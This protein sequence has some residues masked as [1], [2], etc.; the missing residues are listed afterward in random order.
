M[1]F[2]SAQEFVKHKLEYLLTKYT[3]IGVIYTYDKYESEHKIQI[4]PS[5][6][7]NSEEWK[8][9]CII[10][11]K[12]S[13]Q[14]FPSELISFIDTDE[15]LIQYEDL[16]YKKQGI[17]YLF[18]NPSR[19]DIGHKHKE[20]S[21]PFIQTNGLSIIPVAQSSIKIT[22]STLWQEGRPSNLYA[23]AA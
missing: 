1:N 2:I 3:N 14:Q 8:K 4:S 9:E 23:S 11:F 16:L 17:A 18:H 12:E 7:L 22:A 19:A 20:L 15:Y 6:F 10:I 5:S 21:M 13:Y